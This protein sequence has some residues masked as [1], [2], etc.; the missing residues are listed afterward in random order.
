MACGHWSSE[1]AAEFGLPDG[2]YVH[3]QLKMRAGKEQYVTRFQFGLSGKVLYTAT[4]VE[5]I[6]GLGA[7]QTP[8]FQ[9][10]RWGLRFA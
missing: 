2:W 9:E 1:L 8:E 4:E 7:Y 6:L 5:G 10:R 3:R